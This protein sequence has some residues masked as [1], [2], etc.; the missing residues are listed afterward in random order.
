MTA[1]QINKLSNSGHK[2]SFL[3]NILQNS[4]KI[5]LDSGCLYGLSCILNDV[6]SSIF[7]VILDGNLSPQQPE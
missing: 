6:S 3:A 5:E 4:D 1:E 7:D 2:V